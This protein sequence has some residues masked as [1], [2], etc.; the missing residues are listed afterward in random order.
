MPNLTI[1]NLT[2]QSL[3]TSASFGQ[4]RAYETRTRSQTVAEIEQLRPILISLETTGLIEWD[5]AGYTATDGDA[6]FITY[7]DASTGIPGSSAK[8][9]SFV[10]GNAISGDTIADCDFLDPGDGS[11]IQAALTAAAA[12][13][14]GQIFIKRGNYNFDLPTSPVPMTLPDYVGI[15]GENRGSVNFTASSTQRTSF[16]FGIGNTL[17]DIFINQIPAAAGAVGDYVIDLSLADEFTIEGLTIDVGAFNA[18][19][20]MIGIMET[21][22]SLD[23]VFRDMIVFVSSTFP[24]SFVPFIMDLETTIFDNVQ[25]ADLGGGLLFFDVVA[26]DCEFNNLYGD[27]GQIMS[28]SGSDRCNIRSVRTLA[29]GFGPLGTA[30]AVRLSGCSNVMLNG[31]LVETAAAIGNGIDLVACDRCLV[32]D[33]ILQGP[34]V[35]GVSIDAVSTLNVVNGIAV[36]G[37]VTPVTNASANTQVGTVAS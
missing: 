12:T 26:F 19:E 23:C 21:F 1:T 11:G 16:V 37:A 5:V 28:I 18:N 31:V 15:N 36:D 22:G 9:P 13:S 33:C 4:L 35:S 34:F 29:L 10:V 32:T 24:T 8:G 14:G 6:E 7:E 20:S 25:I 3:G 27:C 30:A 2:G 17:R